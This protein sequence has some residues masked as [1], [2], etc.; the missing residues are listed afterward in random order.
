MKTTLA[1]GSLGPLPTR[2]VPTGH[3]PEFVNETTVDRINRALE[4]LDGYIDGYE[5]YYPQA[6]NEENLT[7][8]R[9][10]LGE[11][12][13][14]IVSNALHPDREFARGGLSS[15][16]A[17]TR[18]GA[19]DR[20]RGCIELAGEVGADVIVWPGNEGYNYLFQ[21]DYREA[22]RLLIDA[23]DQAAAL[24]AERGVR[25]IIEPKSSEPAMKILIRNMPA[26]LHVV[27]LLRR[28]GHSN[29]MVNLDWQN[30]LMTEDGLAESAALLESDDALGHLH[31]SSGWGTFDDKTIVGSLNFMEILELAYYLRAK[32]SYAERGGRI[33][34]DLYPYTED[35]VE[36]VRR[37]VEQWRAID[38]IAS[39]I[40]E[41]SLAEAISE[42]DAVRAQRLVYA[43]LMDKSKESCPM[44]G[45]Q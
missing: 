25:L 10:A 2:F 34:F 15:P 33:G 4:G 3:W 44:S 26:A 35:P 21:T 37:S 7:A 29:V 16:Q 19:L 42:R 32:S 18:R 13:I 31:A 11:H 24:C 39:R 9:Q 41:A 43:A 38:A 6:V 30:V 20:T 28:R 5:L 27:D 1:F 23:L 36:A 40:D 8:V 22:W 45:E 14:Y 17:A 12:D